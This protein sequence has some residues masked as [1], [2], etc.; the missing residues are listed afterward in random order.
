MLDT[1]CFVTEVVLDSVL[2]ERFQAFGNTSKRPKGQVLR[3]HFSTSP[4]PVIDTSLRL[5]TNRGSC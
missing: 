3:I 2:V 5:A 4:G 1:A